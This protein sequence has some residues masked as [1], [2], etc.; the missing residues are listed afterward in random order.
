VARK[1]AICAVHVVE[2]VEVHSLR[3]QRKQC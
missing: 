3:H 2:A 1:W